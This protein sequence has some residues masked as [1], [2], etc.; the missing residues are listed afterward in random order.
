MFV[1][2]HGS[3]RHFGA[4][5]GFAQRLRSPFT[6]MSAASSGLAP[7]TDW[8]VA[9]WKIDPLARRSTAAR[10]HLQI[11]EDAAPTPIPKKD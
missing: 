9:Q 11:L 6:K 1:I 10:N 3:S 4:E 7:P 8:P 5:D 2:D